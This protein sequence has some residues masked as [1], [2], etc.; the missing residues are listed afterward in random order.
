MGTNIIIQLSSLLNV[1][2]LQDHKR[3]Q[4]DEGRRS[5]KVKNWSHRFF[6]S[7]L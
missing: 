6:D 2:P 1:I 7:H 5:E 3:S 4:G